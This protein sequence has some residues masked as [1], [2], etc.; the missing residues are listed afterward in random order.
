MRRGSDLPKVTGLVRADLDSTPSLSDAK[1][2][3]GLSRDHQDCSG[4]GVEP[5]VT[6]RN[7]R[8][9]KL[10]LLRPSPQP[11]D[12]SL[13]LCTGLLLPS[14]QLLTSIAPGS[15]APQVRVRLTLAGGRVCG[16]WAAARG[17]MK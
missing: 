8:H 3:R 7:S 2:S 13:N 4:G 6:V 10:Q 11:E 14:H 1:A 17:L 5:W 16:P 12:R 15:C 9:T